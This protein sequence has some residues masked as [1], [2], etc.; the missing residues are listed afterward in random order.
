MCDLQILPSTP[1]GPSTLVIPHN[2]IL[3][4]KVFK[5]CY[6]LISLSVICMI[7]SFLHVLLATLDL[8][9]TFL[10]A[11]SLLAHTPLLIYQ[12]LHLL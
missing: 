7:W 11:E 2:A 3:V 10:T 12:Y 4:V 9:C 5:C 6:S 1:F 8:G